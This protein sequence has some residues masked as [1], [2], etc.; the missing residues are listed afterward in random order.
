MCLTTCSLVSGPLLGVVGPIGGGSLAEGNG[1]Q[2][3]KP[4]FI[5]Q[6]RKLSGS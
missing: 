6:P 1:T 4:V 5:P 2:G 3:V